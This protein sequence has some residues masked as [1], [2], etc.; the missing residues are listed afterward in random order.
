MGKRIA[1]IACAFCGAIAC[2]PTS[3]APTS[4]PRAPSIAVDVREDTRDASIDVDPLITLDELAAQSASVTVGM[5]ELA[6]SQHDDAHVHE[7]LAPR[8]PNA[9]KDVCVRVA[10]VASS[11]VH[12]SIEDENGKARAWIEHATARGL[13]D[14]KG[15]VCVRHDG[16]IVLRID[17]DD[18]ARV[19]W[20][21]WISW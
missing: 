21:A 5:H 15:P 20:I 4:L 12:A 3:N 13:L 8:D 7:L 1:L 9:E 6:R 17:G 18:H 14:S 2:A 11:E 19:R 10:F 16:K